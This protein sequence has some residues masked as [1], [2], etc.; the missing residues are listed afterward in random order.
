MRIVSPEMNAQGQEEGQGGTNLVIV[1]CLRTSPFLWVQRTKL[2]SQGHGSHSAISPPKRPQ[3]DAEF[4]VTF[5]HNGI[6]QHL[7]SQLKVKAVGPLDT[8]KTVSRIHRKSRQ[9][10]HHHLSFTPPWLPPDESP[11]TGALHY[12]KL[13]S[14]TTSSTL[15]QS[16]NRSQV[17][18]SA[19]TPKENLGCRCSITQPGQRHIRLYALLSLFLKSYLCHEESS[20]R[21]LLGSDEEDSGSCHISKSES[22]YR[23][24]LNLFRKER[25]GPLNLIG[26][27]HS[28]VLHVKP[29]GH[30]LWLQLRHPSGATKLLSPTE[31]NWSVID[32]S[33]RSKESQTHMAIWKVLLMNVVKCLL[34]T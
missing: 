5:I 29:P 24:V 28:S 12:V 4:H 31:D 11:P 30:Q 17:A 26:S 32:S 1:G 15:H 18:H 23:M 2:G 25:L 7:N 27:I 10:H 6:R 16:V 3:Q 9:G 21:R 22:E 13:S 19:L 20:L 33:T 34:L 8:K 14:P